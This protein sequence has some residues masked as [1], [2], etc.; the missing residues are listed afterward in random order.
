VIGHKEGTRRKIDPSFD[1]GVFRNAV[2]ARLSHTTD[3][4]PNEETDVPLTD[5]E[6]KKIAERVLTLDGVIDNPNPA[7]AG[8]NK[9][10]SLESS[11]RNIETVTRRTEAKVDA[12]GAVELTDTQLTALANKVAAHP[13]LAAQI[14]EAV[15][16]K[17]AARLAN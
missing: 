10:I 12:L 3:W 14:A 4:N 9:Y 8:T 13:A 7:T 15:A 16:V 11:V 17:L 6:I 1:M 5:A 2:A